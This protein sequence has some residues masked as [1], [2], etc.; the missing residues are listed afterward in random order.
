VHNQ[1]STFFKLIYSITIAL[2]YTHMLLKHHKKTKYIYQ[3]I[4]VY[5]YL[6][7]EQMDLHVKLR[8]L[9]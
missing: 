5:T 8:F 3:L 9:M 4:I 6:Y 1:K 2:T 7:I